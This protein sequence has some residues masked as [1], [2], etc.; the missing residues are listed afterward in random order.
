MCGRFSI[1][2]PSEA[3]GELFGIDD[4]EAFPPR[5]NIAPTQPILVVAE[6]R[7]VV[8]GANHPR[9]RALLARWGLWPS[10][11]KDPRGFPLLFNARAESAAEKAAF[12]AA[13]RYRRVLVPASGFYEWKRSP[14]GKRKSQAY[15]VRPKGGGLV[16]LGGLLETWISADGSEIDTAAILTTQ[17]NREFAAIHPRMPLVIGEENFARWLDCR[18]GD[19]RT[20]ADLLVPV[21]EGMLEA[22]PV[23]DRVNTVANTGPEVQEAVAPPDAGAD[24]PHDGQPEQPSLF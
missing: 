13:M 6:G 15:W 8:A 12:R 24:R 21:Q 2:E 9:R 16:A 7:A 1:T 23:S 18:A 11:M 17:A 5:Y 4:V 10:W 22:V 20:V 14:D 3:V 19:A